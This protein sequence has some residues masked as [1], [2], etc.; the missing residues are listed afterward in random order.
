[1]P[2]PTPIELVPIVSYDPGCQ[3]LNFQ[4]CHSAS[5]VPEP[6][7]AIFFQLFL[8]CVRMN[9]VENQHVNFDFNLSSY[10]ATATPNP[11]NPRRDKYADKQLSINGHGGR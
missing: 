3:S 6:Q 11:S 10:D 2:V 1:M 4:I 8:S 5:P 9:R 7:M